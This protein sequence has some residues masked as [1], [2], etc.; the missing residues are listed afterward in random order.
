MA[1]LV[2]GMFLHIFLLV[3]D[4]TLFEDHEKIVGRAI[5]IR[6]YEMSEK[7]A[8]NGDEEIRRVKVNLNVAKFCT[9]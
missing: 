4:T 8:E 9:N 2:I 5:S 3:V 1:L 7:R 6:G